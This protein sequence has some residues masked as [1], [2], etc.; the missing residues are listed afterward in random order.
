MPFAARRML[1]TLSISLTFHRIVLYHRGHVRFPC[2]RSGFIV[3]GG[4]FLGVGCA[5]IFMLWQ[6]YFSSISAPECNWR[7]IAGTAFASLLYFML[8]LIPDSLTAFSHSRGASADLRTMSISFGARDGLRPIDVRR[9]STRTSTSICAYAPRLLAI[10]RRVGSACLRGRP[11]TRRC[12][13]GTRY[14]NRRHIHGRRAHCMRFLIVAW[15]WFPFNLA[16]DR[17]F[18]RYIPSC[19]Q[20]YC[21]SLFA[22]GSGAYAL[23]QRCIQYFS[24]MVL[25]LMMQ[26]AQIARD[27]GTNPVFA[28]AF[29]SMRIR[30]SST[31]FI[32]G[33][34]TLDIDV[35]GIG[36][37]AILSMLA[38]YALGMSLYFFG[39][40]AFR[41]VKRREHRDAMTKLSSTSGKAWKAPKRQCSPR[42]HR[43]RRRSCRRT[44]RISPTQWT[45][46]RQKAPQNAGTL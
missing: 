27:R 46:I 18:A 17:R 4:A 45:T 37:T 15:R 3:A 26:S 5:G 25:V 20:A 21:S 42:P 38:A 6:R 1:V 40:H 41:T 12:H 44:C 28:Y 8:Y 33:W 9:H 34:I 29:L 24:I 14:S 10:S 32:L 35:M 16:S 23:R 22:Q 13:Y 19:S 31:G 39:R 43:K 30:A 7:L 11:G 2:S 36:K